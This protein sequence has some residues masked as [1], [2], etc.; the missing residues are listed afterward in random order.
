MVVTFEIDGDP[1][2]VTRDGWWD[3]PIAEVSGEASV[4]AARSGYEKPANKQR[5]MW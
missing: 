5:A 2:V 1:R 4:N 3:V